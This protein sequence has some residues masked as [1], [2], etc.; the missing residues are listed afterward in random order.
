VLTTVLLACFHSFLHVRQP[1]E[2]AL[3]TNDIAALQRYQA[4]RQ[5]TNASA[6]SSLQRPWEAT[7]AVMAPAS[8]PQTD[9]PPGHSLRLEWVYGYRA[10]VRA[11][12]DLDV[13]SCRHSVRG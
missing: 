4:Y 2:E 8:Y 9:E 12:V 11:H 7:S 13:A 1:V 10:Q 6:D 3:R 5:L